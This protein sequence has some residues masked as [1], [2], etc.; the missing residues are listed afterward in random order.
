VRLRKALFK[1]VSKE[2]PKELR[3]EAARGQVEMPPSDLTTVLCILSRDRDEEVSRAA[4]SSFE[5]LTTETLF[6]A[7]EGEL[8]PIVHKRVASVQSEREARL[9]E[10]DLEENTDKTAEGKP[11][12]E[13]TSGPEGVE[14]NEEEPAP[15]PEPKVEE[16]KPLSLMEQ[17]RS[18]TA[19]QKIKLA[20]TGD[21]DA[22][23]VLIKEPNEQ[24]TSSVLRNPRIT[25]EEILKL[26]S[27]RGTSDN[28]LRLIAKNKEWMKNYRMKNT[29]VLNPKTPLSISMRLVNQLYDK[30]LKNMSKSKNISTVLANAAD[31]ALQARKRR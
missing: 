26:T 1:Y 3:L 9:R 27:T 11:E 7:M 18:M 25:E 24:I 30:D 14:T 22:R 4:K 31:R 12:G 16:K 21:K 13:E 20:L 19:A 10:A 23:G 29:L 28:I 5:G 2:S 6:E 15:Q 17:I 8:D